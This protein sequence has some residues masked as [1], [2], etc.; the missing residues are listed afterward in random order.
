M[1]QF[2][3]NPWPYGHDVAAVIR[4]DDVSYFTEP[5][6]LSTI[7]DNVWKRGFKVSFAII[8]KVKAIDDP[9]VPPS[10]RGKLLLH[11]LIDNAELVNYLREKL[12]LQ[13]IDISQHGFTHETING[14]PEFSVNDQNEINERL[15]AG[16][17]FLE[18]CFHIKN[19]VF[20]PPWDILSK[21][22]TNILRKE[23]IA[24]CQSEEKKYR[25]LWSSNAS[26]MK[27]KNLA[28]KFSQYRFHQSDKRTN[29]SQPKNGSRH[30]SWRNYSLNFNGI[31][32][33]MHALNGEEFKE[34]IP[35]AIPAASLL[36]ILN[37]YNSYYENYTD[38]VN[39]KM[40]SHFY[41]TLDLLS[42]HN[43]WKTTLSE[44]ADWLKKLNG[45]ELKVTGEKVILTSPVKVNGVT[46][47]G[48]ECNLTSAGN[49]DTE[50]RHEKNSSLLICKQLEAGETE[51]ARIN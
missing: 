7:Y 50:V 44:V 49:I 18:Q 5:H 9:L 34:G 2:S 45:I 14:I 22:A 39:P 35:K 26:L 43:I 1:W 16:R 24:Y 30:R 25:R 17:N 6:K 21:K 13:Q 32:Q 48:K 3:L 31:K 20:I 36:C 28:Q 33:K 41:S 4:D 10:H 11:A 51:I 29:S 42:S 12:N 38:Q 19:P 15:L 27:L 47:N 40:L 23:N 46:I 37:H 8:P